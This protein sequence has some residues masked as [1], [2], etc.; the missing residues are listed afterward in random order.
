M[1]GGA[2]AMSPVH[3]YYNTSNMVNCKKV[4]IFLRKPRRDRLRGSS[5]EHSSIVFAIPTELLN[6]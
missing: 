4:W 5:E 1:R 2:Q 6:S 3:S